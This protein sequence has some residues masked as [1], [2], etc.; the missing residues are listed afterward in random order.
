MVKFF[1]GASAF[2]ST[3]GRIAQG[4]ETFDYLDRS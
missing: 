3:I 4:L 2:L 1:E